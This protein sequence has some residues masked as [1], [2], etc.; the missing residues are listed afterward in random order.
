MWSVFVVHTWMIWRMSFPSCWPD[1][2]TCCLTP[3]LDSQLCWS[4]SV[5][6]L[7]LRTLWSMLSW[8]CPSRPVPWPSSWT[9]ASPV[10]WLSCRC[11]IS[12]TCN[13]CMRNKK[14]IR[15]SEE[16]SLS[17]TNVNLCLHWWSW[18]HKRQYSVA[19]VCEVILSM[20][21]VPAGRTAYQSISQKI[22]GNPNYSLNYII[23][24]II[25]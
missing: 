1:F 5:P 19:T 25:Y 12:S 11:S 9:L 20:I 24:F 3:L 13:F 15:Y 7:E 14:L 22:L 23:L 21:T 8:L 4:A 10:T 16:K 17:R 6:L 18:G 2:C